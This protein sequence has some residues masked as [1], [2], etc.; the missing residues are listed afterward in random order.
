MTPAFQMTPAAH[1]Q[2]AISADALATFL[3]TF[4]TTSGSSTAS[5]ASASLHADSPSSGLKQ[6]TRRAGKAKCGTTGGLG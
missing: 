4:A 5:A 3:F 6:F 1:E 2:N